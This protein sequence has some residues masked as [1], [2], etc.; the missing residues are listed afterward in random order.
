M[1][2]IVESRY[3]LL[4]TGTFG[5]APATAWRS[6]RSSTHQ[7]FFA[8]VPFQN[9]SSCMSGVASIAL[10]PSSFVNSVSRIVVTARASASAVKVLVPSRPTDCENALSSA[11]HALKSCHAARRIW[12]SPVF[13]EKRSIRLPL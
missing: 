6:V 10:P 5:S 7:A 11:C 8:T 13:V 1:P 2:G 4:R 12:Y 3:A 9:T